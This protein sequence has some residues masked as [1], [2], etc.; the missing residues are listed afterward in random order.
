MNVAKE[1]GFGLVLSAV[2]LILHAWVTV[3]NYFGLFAIRTGLM[4]ALVQSVILL[5][6]YLGI[7]IFAVLGKRWALVVG[8][9]LGVLI[10]LL[11]PIVR[12]GFAIFF[13][14]I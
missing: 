4:I 9:V 14:F 6:I 5:L 7:L 8:M 13:I 3:T 11:L 2:V 12:E 1:F 10:D